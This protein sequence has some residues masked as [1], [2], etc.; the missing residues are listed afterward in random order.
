[1]TE[2]VVI[3]TGYKCNNHC[4]FCCAGH[5]RQIGNLSTIQ[6]KR[7]LEDARKNKATYVDFIGGEAT[8]RKDIFELVRYAKELGYD[9]IKTTTNGR[10]YSYKWF[11]KII[12]EEGLNG[13][14]FSIH[15]H[16]AELH[17]Y[18]TRSKG[19]FEQAMQGIRNLQKLGVYVETNTVIARPNYKFLPKVEELFIGLGIDNSEFVWL[20]TDPS[21]YAFTDFEGMVVTLTEMEPFLHKTLDIGRKHNIKHIAANY[22]PLCYM[23]GY[24][25]H[26]VNLFFE[27]EEIEHRAK[28]FVDLDVVKHRKQLARVH[29]PQCM[30][31]KYRNICEGIWK[32]YAN[33]LGFKELRAIKGEVIKNNEELMKTV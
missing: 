33:K 20:D 14:I 19:A 28:D 29:G 4:R 18:L 13:C 26:V 17:D 1:M 9:T 2:R 7:A 32:Q 12:V 3:F 27:P 11:A 8:I 23:Q 31:C 10:M 15:G 16:N 6:I 30:E 22:V 25:N 21:G 5:K 24:E